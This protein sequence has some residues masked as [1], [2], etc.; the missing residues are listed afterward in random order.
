MLIYLIGYMGSGKS[1]IGKK[2]AARLGYDFIDLDK[3]IE[4][5]YKIS[6]PDLFSRYDEGA[7]RKLEKETL[8][9]TFKLKSKVIST[10]GGTPC[11]Y[12]NMDLINKNGLSVYLKMHPKSL[13]ERLIKS[14]KKRPLI[15]DK[16]PDEILNHITKHLSEREFY[17]NQSK[18]TFK[19]ENLDIKELKKSIKNQ[20]L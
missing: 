18:M 17:Y 11:F 15:A 9:E 7:F 5:K 13:Y 12:N 10:G 16:P 4:H 2:L 3:M 14:K 6:I 8:H 20:I 1:T 19:G